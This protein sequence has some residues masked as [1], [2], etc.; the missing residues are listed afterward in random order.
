MM[1]FIGSGLLLGGLLGSRFTVLALLPAAGLS[2]GAAALAW[3]A[4][5]GAPGWSFLD[6]VALLVSLQLG[7]VCGAG[8][9]LTVARSR[10]LLFHRKDFRRS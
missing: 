1:L 5:T 8:L 6:L 3:A 10:P 2:V 7:Y 9:R 4:H